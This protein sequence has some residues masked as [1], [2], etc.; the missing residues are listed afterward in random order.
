LKL[1]G[2]RLTQVATWLQIAQFLV[3]SVQSIAQL[4]I[5]LSS[6]EVRALHFRPSGDL[7]KDLFPKLGADLLSK[8]DG[9]FSYTKVVEE[10]HNPDL[11][12]NSETELKELDVEGCPWPLKVQ[13]MHHW[14]SKGTKNQKRD[15]PKHAL[16]AI[17]EALVVS[18]YRTELLQGSAAARFLRTGLHE[19]LDRD[20]KKPT[21]SAAR[22]P[23]EGRIKWTYPDGIHWA[24]QTAVSCTNSRML[25]LDHSCIVDG[26]DSG[27]EVVGLMNKV[28]RHKTA[29]MKPEDPEYAGMVAPEVA[30]AVKNLLDVGGI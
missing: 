3:D 6:S 8:S 7:N 27:H 20:L 12:R 17:S 1:K 14:S 16:M 21:G 24:C 10:M 30:D 4:E 19:I 23:K 22:L 15:L 25:L 18:E 29:L 13:S 5:D 26:R 9:K 11:K 28:L 2:K